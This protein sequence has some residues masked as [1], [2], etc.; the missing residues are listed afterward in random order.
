MLFRQSRERHQVLG[1]LTARVMVTSADVSEV[2]WAGKVRI[3]QV[4]FILADEV[5]SQRDRPVRFSVRQGRRLR[6]VMCRFDG[7]MPLDRVRALPRLN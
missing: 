3:G 7:T 6:D 1:Y 4:I 2:T 5:I